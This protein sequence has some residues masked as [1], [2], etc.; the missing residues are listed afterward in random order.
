MPSS[1]P[2]C[3]MSVNA[4]EH[5]RGHEKFDHDVPVYSKPGLS[6]MGRRMR[7]F[8][9]SEAGKAY[10][11]RTREIRKGETPCQ[12]VS[13]VCTGVAEHQHED[14][15]RAKSGGIEAAIRKGTQFF[16]ACDPCNSFCSENQV[17]ARE[18]GFIVRARDIE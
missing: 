16:P 10:N 4:S 13:P 12:I 1:C 6:P 8:N 15:T 3:G 18:R 5:V 14:K 2:Q 7:R 9:E 17:W 11:A